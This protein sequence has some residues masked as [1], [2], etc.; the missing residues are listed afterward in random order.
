MEEK[1]TG[2]WR[3]LHDDDLHDLYTSPGIRVIKSRRMRWARHVVNMGEMR[4]TYKMLIANSEGI[5]PLGIY[6]RRWEDNVQINLEE[7]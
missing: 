4:N 1:V 6:R 2:Q 3:K 7:I 5:R